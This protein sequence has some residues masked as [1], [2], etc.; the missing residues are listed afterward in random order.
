MPDLELLKFA[1]A[2]DDQSFVWRIAAAMT[3]EAQ[4]KFGAQ[5]DMSREARML[6]EWTL[7]HPMESDPTMIAFVS[8]DAGIASHII[9]NEGLI[10]TSN[11]PDGAIRTVV[12]A[13]W[14]IVANRRFLVTS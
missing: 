12:G 9:I 6:M 3:L 14:D 5:P 1:R 11:V 13:R 10:D 2:R 4:Y 7:D 8:T